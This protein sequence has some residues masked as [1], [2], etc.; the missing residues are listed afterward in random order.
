[1]VVPVG[2]TAVRDAIEKDPP[3]LVLP[4]RTHP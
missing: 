3:L 1:M 4:G 2:S